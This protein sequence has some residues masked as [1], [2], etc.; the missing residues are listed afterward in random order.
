MPGHNIT[1]P[2]CTQHLLADALRRAGLKGWAVEV[3][4]EKGCVTLNRGWFLTAIVEACVAL[5][6]HSQ[7]CLII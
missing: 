5:L 4:F 7:A 3:D 6:S 2:I 1:A